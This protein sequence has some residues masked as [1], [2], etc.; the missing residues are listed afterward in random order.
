MVLVV[1]LSLGL[2]FDI[3]VINKGSALAEA[4]DSVQSSTLLKPEHLCSPVGVSA[5]L[6][7]AF[8]T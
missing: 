3:R 7:V 1:R 5:E 6:L 4:K 2:R 8:P